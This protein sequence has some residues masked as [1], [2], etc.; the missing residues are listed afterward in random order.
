M[1]VRST[2]ADLISLTRELISD[3][4]L[5]M[6]IEPTYLNQTQTLATQTE[7]AYFTTEG[8]ITLTLPACS[9][10]HPAIHIR[11]QDG[12]T[13]LTIQRAG[14]DTINGAATSI[15]LTRAY[16]TVKI[17]PQAAAN[18]TAQLSEGL[19]FTD[20]QVQDALDREQTRVVLHPL[21]N[22]MALEDPAAPYTGF[23]VYMALAGFWEADTALYYEDHTAATPDVADLR[24][25]FW[26]FNARQTQEI[27]ARG[28]CYDLPG[29]AASLLIRWADSIKLEYQFS[30]ESGGSYSKQ[31]RIDAMLRLVE[32]YRKQRRPFGIPAVE[33]P[34]DLSAYRRTL[35]RQWGG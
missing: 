4:G 6:G 9:A 11:K 20:Q 3:L 30:T 14:A 34:D 24:A 10:V 21:V 17:F 35:L 13:T 27:Y 23:Y 1:A 31:Q 29:A 18:W 8:A 22:L 12:T 16:N 7:E 25:G 19:T 26:Q 32:D 5:P 28:N 15:T 33:Q 2:M